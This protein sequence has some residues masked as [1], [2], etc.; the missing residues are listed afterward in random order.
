MFFNITD[1]QTQC[2]KI[3]NNSKLE[4]IA[5]SEDGKYVLCKL[6]GDTSKIGY[7]LKKHCTPTI[8]F[9]PN[10]NPINPDD[11]QQNASLTA[12]DSSQKNQADKAKITRIVLICVLCVFAVL[13][14]FLIFKPVSFKHK[15]NYHNDFYDA[16]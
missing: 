7:V 5:Y 10:P 14:V 4:F 12:D 3:A 2:I 1:E 9:T 13:V 6:S 11:E 16:Q 15:K 8:I